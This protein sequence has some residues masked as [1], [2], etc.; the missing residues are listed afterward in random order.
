[1]KN[2][3]FLI[4]IS[5]NIINKSIE[6]LNTLLE[7]KIFLR[8]IFLLQKKQ[9]STVVSF[10]EILNDS[11]INQL[12]KC[13]NS[14][15]VKNHEKLKQ[16][17]NNLIDYKLINKKIY[18]NNITREKQ[19]V[20]FIKNFLEESNSPSATN[21]LEINYKKPKNIF[22]L[23]ENNIG[24]LNPMIVDELIEAEKKYPFNWVIDAVKESVTRNKRNWKYIH[25]ILETWNTEGKT[26]GR[27][28]GNSE[29]TG[30]GKYFKR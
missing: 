25:T 20:F 11:K 6:S 18:S 17:C 15:S 9:N 14:I 3:D 21:T 10:E 27:T 24:L 8:I 1:M 26:N 29:K 7:I 22:E 19:I 2:N 28:L 4:N 12:L 23:Y 30:Y 13:E 16:I 5:S